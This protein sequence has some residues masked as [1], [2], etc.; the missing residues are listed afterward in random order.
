MSQSNSIQLPQLAWYEDT[1][2]EVDFPATWDVHIC[3]MEG[4]DAVPLSEEGIREAFRNPIGSRTIRELAAGKKE[5]AII[6]DDMTR[7]TPTA[8]VIPYVLEEL[9]TA[10]IT[11]DHIRFIAAIATHGA[12]NGIDFRKKLGDDVM[13]R[14]LVYNHNPYENCTPLGFTRQG[15]PVSINSEFM[16]C[17]LKIGIGSIV[18]HPY[19]GF[20]GGSKIVLPGVASME[21]IDANHSRLSL[22]PTIGIGR[23]ENNA[24]KQDMDETAKMAGLDIK[25]DAI[26]NMKR[27]ITA[28]F[29]GDP[30]EEHVEGCKLATRHY[31]TEFVHD[32]EVVVANC[33]AKSNEM[34]LAP[35]IAAPLLSGNG[36][37]DMVVVAVTPEG[38]ITHYWGRSFGKTFGGRAWTPK[39][40]L[41]PH[42]K[43]LTVLAPYP[44]RVGGDWMAPYD[45]INWAR[46]W[47]EVLEGLKKDYGDRAKVAVIPDATIQYFPDAPRE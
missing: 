2:L 29:V 21:T 27:E 36:G 14:F 5:V 12:M 19:T 26:M 9:A 6:F 11:D 37:G 16:A 22:S 33:Y 43:K 17:D 39:K 23:Y 31:A 15:T 35:P 38:Q 42:T 4:H 44:D 32:V 18:P 25:V 28:L 7:A 46:S 1:M 20:G 47:P 30:V 8:A 10:G 45:L 34:V 3:R 40:T 24:V 13:D 41:P